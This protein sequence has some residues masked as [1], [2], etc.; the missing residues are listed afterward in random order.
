MKKSWYE[1]KY[2]GGMDTVYNDISEVKAH[3]YIERL[4]IIRVISL[5][6]LM[7]SKPTCRK[8]P[9]ACRLQFPNG[10]EG[11]CC[12]EVSEVSARVALSGIQ[13]CLPV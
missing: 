11:S 3:L 1:Y 9:K 6:L 8:P 4:L 7:S 10:E 2:S 12:G 5:L 13:E